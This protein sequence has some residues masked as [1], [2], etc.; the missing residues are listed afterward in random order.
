MNLSRQ[1]T[2]TTRLFIGLVLKF[3][4]NVSLAL[5]VFF[6]TSADMC[7]LQMKTI[8]KLFSTIYKDLTAYILCD[9]R[10]TFS[11]RNQHDFSISSDTGRERLI[12]TRLI[13][14]ST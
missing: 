8:C 10:V 4:I 14:S 3:I 6:S 1:K 12:R 7:T 2:N 11:I 13:R 5:Y 9:F